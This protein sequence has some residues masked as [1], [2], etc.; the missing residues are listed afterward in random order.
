MNFLNCFS[1]PTESLYHFEI[2][3]GS[4]Y[5]DLRGWFYKTVTDTSLDASSYNIFYKEV[6]VKSK[7]WS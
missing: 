5:G 6:F 4:Q 7:F 1:S 3:V 2:T